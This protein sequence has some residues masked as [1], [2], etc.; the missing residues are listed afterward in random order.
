MLGIDK[1]DQFIA[2][3]R[4][5]IRC[6]RTWIPIMLHSL[7]ILRANAYI[8]H[9]QLCRKEE[10]SE[11]DKGHKSFLLIKFIESFI[12]CATDHKN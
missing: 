5:K 3:Y 11:E 10:E 8:I 1:A 4:P 9:E 12:C 2:Y 6:R 7:D